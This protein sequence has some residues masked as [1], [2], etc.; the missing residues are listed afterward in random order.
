MKKHLLSV[1]FSLIMI[2]S[3]FPISVFA[4]NNADDM[5]FE[6]ASTAIS[7]QDAENYQ[8]TLN[9]IDAYVRSLQEVTDGESEISRQ[10]IKDAVNQQFA[11]VVQT[12]A[13]FYSDYVELAN[14]L[15]SY[16]GV[17]TTNLAII[18]YHGYLAQDDAEDRE[19]EDAY[20]HST[21]NFRATKAL[22]ATTVRIYTIDYEWANQLLTL[23]QNYY[24]ERYD[25][26]FDEY[27]T[28]I[29]WGLMDVNTIMTMAQADADDYICEYKSALQTSCRDSYSTFTSTFDN[30]N[31]MDWWNNKIGRDYGT[32]YSSYTPEEMFNAACAAGELILNE[33]DAA[34]KTYDLWAY[35][36][37]WY[38]GT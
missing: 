36:N 31:V 38:T 28:S 33:A 9:Q 29:I 3:L 16:D 21:W 32:N 20:R 24:D 23:W 5:V 15:A 25:Y 27:Y 1:I 6:A 12:R 4:A 18:M 26:Y 37:W 10:E 35:T 7:A 17:S 13:Y 2:S 11:N 19:Y 30:A 8:E 22:S 34:S 14:V